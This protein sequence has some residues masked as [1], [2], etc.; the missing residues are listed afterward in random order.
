MAKDSL[1]KIRAKIDAIDDQIIDLLAERFQS[2]S[3]VAEWKKKQGTMVYQPEREEAI[4]KRILERGV[5]LG[6]NPLLLQA[7]F[8]Q[9]F[10]VSKREQ[11]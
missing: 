1:E 11:R 8:M 10:A 4:L 9:I 3:Q 6:L 7:L 2:V 5:K